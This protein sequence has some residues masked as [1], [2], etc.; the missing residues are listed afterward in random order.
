MDAIRLAERYTDCHADE[1]AGLQADRQVCRHVGEYAHIIKD[2]QKGIETNSEETNREKK[3]S[4]T[5][6]FIMFYV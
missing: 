5:S 2:T 4:R 3:T 1:Q 6:K